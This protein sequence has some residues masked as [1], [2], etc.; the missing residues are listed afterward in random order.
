MRRVNA[1]ILA[2]LCVLYFVHVQA[3]T[4][5]S[6]HC[7]VLQQV[8]RIQLTAQSQPSAENEHESARERAKQDPSNVISRQQGPDSGGEWDIW[9]PIRM[10]S[11]NPQDTGSLQILETVDYSTASD[12]TDDDVLNRVSIEYGIAPDHSISLAAPVLLFDGEAQGNG[13]L[14]TGWQWRLWDENSGLPAFA[15]LNELF[16]PSGYHA[17]G[18]DWTFTGLLTK[19]ITEKWRLHLNPFLTVAS[20][21]SPSPSDTSHPGNLRDFQWGFIT[22]TDYLVAEHVSVMLDYVHEAGEYTG[23]RNQHYA[24]AGMMWSISEHHGLA[25]ATRW[26]M[27]GDGVED[28]FGASVTYSYSF[29]VPAIGK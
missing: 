5:A 7:A 21:D 4:A 29:D 11:A 3:S 22:G 28:N 27:D 18:L 24:E 2:I 19:S 25:L 10:Q 8:P 17:G 14:E 9:A 26:T 20:G 13:N 23:D 12:H 15:L 16:I 1:M 6:G